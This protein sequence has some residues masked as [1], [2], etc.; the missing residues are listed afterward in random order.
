[1]AHPLLRLLLLSGPTANHTGNPALLHLSSLCRAFLFTI[2]RCYSFALL[3]C[4]LY[5]LKVV[6]SCYT[7]FNHTDCIIVFWSQALQS[8]LILEFNCY[9]TCR[10]WVYV[11]ISR[12]I[13]KN[14][15][16]KICLAWPSYA[17]KPLLVAGLTV[18]GCSFSRV[19]KVSGPKSL[20]ELMVHPLASR[21]GSFAFVARL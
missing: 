15:Q 10:R 20:S 18:R 4:P 3:A 9:S 5:T 11:I 12:I 7:R 13:E 21:E 1:M 16:G 17:C 2:P 6:F 14:Q 8:Q 19:W